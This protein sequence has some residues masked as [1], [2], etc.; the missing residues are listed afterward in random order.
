MSGQNL[1]QQLLN[2]GCPVFIALPFGFFRQPVEGPQVLRIQFHRFAQVG[3]RLRG[4]AALAL[5][6]SQQVVDAIVLRGQIARPFE[7]LRRGVVV[8][9]AQRQD[10]PVGPAGGLGGNKLRHLRELAVGVH[11]VAHLQRRQADIEC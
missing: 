8:S 2:F 9:L 3:N 6:N 7:S 1:L 5:Q 4:L 11:I 10:S